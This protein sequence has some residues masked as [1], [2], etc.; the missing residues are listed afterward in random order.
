MRLQPNPKLPSNPADGYARDLQS[1][2]YR[3]VDDFATQ[4]NKVSEGQIDGNHNA[5]TAAPTTGTYAQ[6]DFVR[7]KAPTELGAAASKYVIFGWICVASGTPGTFLPM[8]MLTG[9]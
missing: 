5:L 3:I 1:K 8:R 4:I 6:G 7:N 2:L 9:N